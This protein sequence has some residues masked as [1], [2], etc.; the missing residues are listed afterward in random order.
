M[1][2][3]R[4]FK[5]FKIHKNSYMRSLY[6]T[7]LE[8]GGHGQEIWNFGHFLPQTDDFWYNRR[9]TDMDFQRKFKNF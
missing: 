5:N 2:F 7:N 1:D 8:Y 9:L 3:E 4:K 6:I